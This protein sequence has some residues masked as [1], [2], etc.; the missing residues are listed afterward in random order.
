RAAE[1]HENEIVALAGASEEIVLHSTL[2]K[3][4]VVL[5]RRRDEHLDVKETRAVATCIERRDRRTVDEELF[6]PRNQ[7]VHASLVIRFGHSRIGRSV[8]EA[9][10]PAG[11]E[12]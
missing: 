7:V 5:A 10:L 4:R 8:L 11:G 3:E 6:A 9:R 12:R 2:A 1:P